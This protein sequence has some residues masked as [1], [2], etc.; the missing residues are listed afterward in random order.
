MKLQASGI[1]QLILMS[2][3]QIRTEVPFIGKYYT[4]V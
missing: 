2:L 3:S 1:S 4:F